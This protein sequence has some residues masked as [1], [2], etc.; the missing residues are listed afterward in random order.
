MQRLFWKLLPGP[1]LPCSSDICGTQF[2]PFSFQL[3]HDNCCHNHG[4]PCDLQGLEGFTDKEVGEQTCGDRFQGCR[5]GCPCGADVV[6]PH[7]KETKRE[8][9][10]HNGYVENSPPLGSCKTGP[11]ILEWWIQGMPGN[12]RKKEGIKKD[13]PGGIAV[14]APFTEKGI[15]RKAEGR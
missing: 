13:G 11:D 3:E 10:S 14:H 6:Y 5:N 9:G 1:I 12:R 15:Y 2:I 4:A 7:E 8:N